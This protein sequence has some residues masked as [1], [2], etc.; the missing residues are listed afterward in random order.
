MEGGIRLC[1]VP[2]KSDPA[3]WKDPRHRRGLRGEEEAKQYLLANGW[4]VTDHRF[5]M[6]RL[7]ID[8]VARKG[9]LVAFIEV[10]TRRGTAFGS[11]FEAVGW[12]KKRE[13]VRV[14]R[15]WMDRH[16]QPGDVYRFDVI[17][18]T[19]DETGR[20]EIGHVEDAF[21]PGWR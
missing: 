6:G 8:L 15:A 12:G 2:I 18:L 9:S 1:A 19:I 21:R 17:G 14:S 13:I 3:S 4:T 11:P 5:R 20:T 7:E 10:K 16:G